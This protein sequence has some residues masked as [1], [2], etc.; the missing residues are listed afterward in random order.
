MT[1][2]AVG[3]ATGG[4]IGNTQYA[5][6]GWTSC[7]FDGTT[8]FGDYIQISTTIAGDCHDTGSAT[9]PTSGAVIGRVQSTNAGTGTAAN[10]NLYSPGITG[11]LAANYLS[12]GGAV[13]DSNGNYAIQKAAMTK[14]PTYNVVTNS[15]FAGGAGALMGSS[16][17]VAGTSGAIAIG[18]DALNSATC[19]NGGVAIGYQAAFGYQC[20][21][22]GGEDGNFVNIGPFAADAATSEIEDV[23]LGNKACEDSPTLD[24]NIC[25]GTHI[26]NGNGSNLTHNVLIGDNGG[27]AGGANY[28][29][30][31][32]YNTLVVPRSW[33][34]LTSP[35]PRRR[36]VLTQVMIL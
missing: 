14:F 9:Y 17:S 8:T 11:A 33:T 19:M 24:D 12:V 13:T 7:I 2:V 26:Y 6:S 28:S 22:T 27:S 3:G 23:V 5:R 29:F 34:P 16:N 35:H 31:Q 4:T 10:V 21:N 36:M 20:Q 32:L 15:F 25:I 30:T 18:Y 1:G